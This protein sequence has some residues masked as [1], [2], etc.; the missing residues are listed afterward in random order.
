MIDVYNIVGHVDYIKVSTMKG[1][2]EMKNIIN[3]VLVDHRLYL[4]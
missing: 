2:I 1:F 3:Q 4:C